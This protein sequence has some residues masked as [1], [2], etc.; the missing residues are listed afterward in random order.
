[1][2]DTFILSKENIYSMQLGKSKAV[3]TPNVKYEVFGSKLFASGYDYITLDAPP[4]P[5]ELEKAKTLGIPV[6]EVKKVDL[7]NNDIFYDVKF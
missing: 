6:K 5:A 1:M 7:G 4:T 3:I 2:M